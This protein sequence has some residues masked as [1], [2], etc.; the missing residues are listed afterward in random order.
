LKKNSSSTMD[1]DE[2]SRGRPAA[3]VK[4]TGKAHALIGIEA[5]VDGFYGAVSDLD[6]MI[7]SELR[8]AVDNGEKTSS[9]SWRSSKSFSHCPDLLGKRLGYWRR[10]TVHRPQ[11]EGE[12][13]LT[14][15]LGWRNLPLRTLLTDHFGIPVFVDNYPNLAAL[16][17]RGFGPGQGP[18]NLVRPGHRPRRWRRT[19][20]HMNYHQPFDQGRRSQ[21]SAGTSRVPQCG[22]DNPCCA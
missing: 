11:P 15:G 22:L 8:V 16:G 10:R 13:I 7:Q 5:S 19:L 2:T 20:M 21:R 1:F 17:Q 3:R 14:M 12:V 6:G 18:N 4:F 9:A